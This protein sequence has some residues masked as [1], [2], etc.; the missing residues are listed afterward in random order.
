MN[1]GEGMV[2]KTKT[3]A[4]EVD[5]GIPMVT[6]KTCELMLCILFCLAVWF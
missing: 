4:S 2:K 6:F 1:S 5:E 3:D